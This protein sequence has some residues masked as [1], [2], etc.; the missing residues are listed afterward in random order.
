MSN[1]LHKK[2]YGV[3]RPVV[4]HTRQ[5]QFKDDKNLLRA[6]PGGFNRAYQS[7]RHAGGAQ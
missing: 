4:S 5:L 1:Q 6:P 7:W 2:I 3:V